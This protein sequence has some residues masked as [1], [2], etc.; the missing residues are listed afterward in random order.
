MY[1]ISQADTGSFFLSTWNASAQASNPTVALAVPN[2]RITPA[3]GLGN[4]SRVVI[5]RIHTGNV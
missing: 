2:L 1:V 4:T 3:S 5:K